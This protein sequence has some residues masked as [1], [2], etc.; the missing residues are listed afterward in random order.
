MSFTPNR[1]HPYLMLLV[2]SA[3]VL[4]CR[5]ERE[6]TADTAAGPFEFSSDERVAL[7][8]YVLEEPT[9]DVTN[10]LVSDQGA[11]HLGQFLF[12]DTR[13][14][15]SGEFAC[16]TCHDPAHAFTDGLPISEATGSTARHAPTLLNTVYNEWF[17]WDGRADSHWAQALGPIEHV[18]EQNFTRLQVAHLLGSDEELTAAYASVFGAL[19]D[20]SDPDRFPAQGRPDPEDP[21]SEI[22]QNW[23]SMND[24]DQ[25]TV[26][27]IFVNVG[28]AIAAYEAQLIAVSAPFDLAVDAVVQGDATGGDSLSLSAKRGLRLF[29]GEGQCHLCHFG[30]MLTNG[31]FH[32]IGLGPRDHLSSGDLGRYSGIDLVQENPFNGA[33]HYSDDREHGAHQL[34]Y[35]AQGAEHMGAFKV[36]TLRNVGETAPY[37]HGGHFD[38]LTEVVE[39]YNELDETPTMGHR[40]ESL[41]PLDLSAEAI[42]D[43]VAFLESLSGSAVDASLLEQ[44]ASPLLDGR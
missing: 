33:G 12:F 36:P 27:T 2:V 30:P 43:V 13:L 4:G 17:F 1:H 15:G 20:L 38:T 32:N 3:L 37:M 28:K 24:A 23:A 25:E 29:L 39:Y 5:Y 31:A 22:A 42:A 34:D 14:S 16:S 11:A 41:L 6:D 35:L 40:E 10:A 44:P 18:D 21:S 8:R 7:S 26:N 19:P 9:P